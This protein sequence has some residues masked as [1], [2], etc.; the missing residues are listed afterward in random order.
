MHS[1]MHMLRYHVGIRV[2]VCIYVRNLC[3][4]ASKHACMLARSLAGCWLAGL[5]ACNA[6]MHA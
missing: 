1:S 2:Y 4:N 6:C 5:Y 3:S